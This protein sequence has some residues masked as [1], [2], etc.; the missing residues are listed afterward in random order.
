VAQVQA[1]V[2]GRP[3]SRVW[4]ILFEARLASASGRHAVA[5]ALIS[6]AQTL[7]EQV[8]KEAQRTRHVLGLAAA[9]ID[10]A[11]GNVQAARQSLQ[12]SPLPVKARLLRRTCQQRT[13]S[14][15]PR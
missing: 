2:Q 12:A 13:C 14:S 15:Q 4:A 3:Q 7:S 11:A 10:L 9:E 6:E 8:F 5:Q 1:Q